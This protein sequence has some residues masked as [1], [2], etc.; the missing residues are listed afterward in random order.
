MCD[1]AKQY[2]VPVILTSSAGVYGDGK[3]P[4]KENAPLNPLSP[5]GTSKVL[6][7][8]YLN[9][10]NRMYGMKNINL[11]LFNV[12]GPGK[13][14]GLLHNMISGMLMNESM[15]IYGDGEQTRDFVSVHD[16]CEAIWRAGN[17]KKLSGTFN[18]G[19]GKETSVNDVVKILHGIIKCGSV[20]RHVKE[21]KGEIRRSCADITL[22]KKHLSWK[23][24][25]SVAKGLKE[26]VV[27]YD[28][29]LGSEED[30]E[31]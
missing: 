19:T 3:V 4:M 11:R 15:I 31:S 27:W 25:I 16:V 26:L 14:K 8:L 5:Y 24:K 29:V 17:L 18:I 21:R 2:G 28:D 30:A 7:E 6:A 20:V 13:F 9:A 12:I 1:I 10:Y 23:P 22:A